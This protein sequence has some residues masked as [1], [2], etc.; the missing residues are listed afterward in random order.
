MNM[1]ECERGGVEKK[2]HQT[3][4]AAKC[5]KEIH[6]LLSLLNIKLRHGGGFGWFDISKQIFFFLIWKSTFLAESLWIWWNNLNLHRNN[7]DEYLWFLFFVFVPPQVFDLLIIRSEREQQRGSWTTSGEYRD[8]IMMT[9]SHSVT[10]VKVQFLKN[11]SLW[12]MRNI[13][14]PATKAKRPFCKL[15]F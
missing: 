13:F 9:C 8:W 11:S 7:E 4:F 1:R 5:Q 2:E 6:C 3:L 12:I 10:T 15:L 14:R